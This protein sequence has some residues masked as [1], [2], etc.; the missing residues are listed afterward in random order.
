MGRP[1]RPACRPDVRLSRPAWLVGGK[2]DC[3]VVDD[4]QALDL[5]TMAW[6]AV[7]S[8]TAGESCLRAGG[9]SCDALCVPP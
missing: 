6:E 2:T 4:V 3:G 9:L 8:A 5:S 7:Q 1:C